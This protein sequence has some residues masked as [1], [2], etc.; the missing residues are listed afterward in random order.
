MFLG[1]ISKMLL[2]DGIVLIS[3][4]RM[5]GRLLRFFL[6]L[7]LRG[8]RVSTASF[9]QAIKGELTFGPDGPS[10]D[11]PK[12]SRKAS[13]PS[14]AHNMT[15]LHERLTGFTQL[16]SELE[17]KAQTINARAEVAKKLLH[18]IE[19]WEEK[20]QEKLALMQAELG[21]SRNKSAN[22]E[23]QQKKEEEF[24]RPKVD[25]QREMESIESTLNKERNKRVELVEKLSTVETRAQEATYRA[26]AEFQESKEY[27]DEL[28]ENYVG[29][30]RIGFLDCKKVVIRMHTKLDL[31]GLMLESLFDENNLEG[32][33]EVDAMEDHP[34]RLS[35]FCTFL[36]FSHIMNFFYDKEMKFL[37][38]QWN[39]HL[40]T[41]FYLPFFLLHLFSC[42][43]AK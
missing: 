17:D 6:G 5:S 14:M 4:S 13:P 3:K 40:P 31:I 7:L 42:E 34:P 16:D 29:A 24:E 2:L 27:E 1:M 39:G 30:Y 36:F 18:A 9:H 32:N 22:L 25:F 43:M 19:E 41:S 15:I 12:K 23:D 37:F 26:L 33:K 10:R 38:F 11:P 20:Y 21:T 28:V 35:I 8:M